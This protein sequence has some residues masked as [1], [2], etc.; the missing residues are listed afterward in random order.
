[1]GFD[2]ALAAEDYCYVTTTGRSSGEPREIE[3]WFGLREGVLYMLAGG[4][5]RANWVRNIMRD[6]TVSVRVAGQTLAGTARIVDDDGEA[7]LA[8]ALL[9]EKYSRPGSDDL[10]RWRDSALPVAVELAG[11]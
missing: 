2:L 9:F 3:I 10:A 7:A 4:R 1:M 6:P 5:E 8:R 11:R